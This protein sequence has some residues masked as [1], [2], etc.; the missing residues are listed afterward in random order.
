MASDTEIARA[1]EDYLKAYGYTCGRNYADVGDVID[2]VAPRVHGET[3]QT[4]EP[5]LRR[6]IAT[7]IYGFKLRGNGVSAS[8]PKCG[9]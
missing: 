1:T 4:M 2:A 3:P 6:I 5:K 7:P 8:D 9:N